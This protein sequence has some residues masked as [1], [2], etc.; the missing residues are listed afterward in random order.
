MKASE[1]KIIRFLEGHDKSFIIPVYQRNYDWNKDNCKQLFD[2]LIDVIKNKRTSHFF[3]SIVYLDNEETDEN[4]RELVI[5]DGQQRITTLTLLMIA[6]LHIHEEGKND[7]KLDTALIKDEY[8]V[9]KYTNK[10]KVKL[11]PVK[12]DAAALK[13]IFDKNWRD[14]SASNLVA[15]YLYFKE[16][17]QK[18]S[19]LP[20][21]IFAAIKRLDIVDIR[22]KNSEDDPQLIFESLNS[23]GLDLSEAD[24]VRN[25]ILMRLSNDKQNEY[26]EKFWNN[27]E[28]NTK[29]NVSGF[30]RD[31]LTYKERNI[32]KEDRVYFTF[33]KYA[34]DSK[35]T[36]ENI[37]EELLIFSEYYS[38]IISSE[39]E[40]KGIKEMLTYL[41]KLNMTVTYPFLLEVF[42]DYYS[43]KIISDNDLFEI[44]SI[45][46]AFIIR[47][48]ICEVPTNALNKLFM[49]LGRE[50]KDL[51]DYKE[52]YVKIF[53]YIL[54]QKR[55][56]QRFPNDNE[57]KGRMIVKDLYNMNAKNSMHILERL[58]NFQNREKID[59]QKLLA[60]NILT[61][62]H[63]MPQ[64]LSKKW[65]DEIGIEHEFIHSTY[66]HTIGNLTLT[67]Y[68][69]EM[70]NKSFSEKKT[71][72]GGFEQS[73]L[74]LNEYVKQ[75]DAWNK[76][77]I[78]ERADILANRALK[79]WQF[80]A[81]DY[82]SSKDIENTYSL[83]EDINFTG[84][85][86][87]YFTFRGQKI[88]VNHW[89]I[90]LQQLCRVLYDMEPIK[91]RNLMYDDEFNKKPLLLSDDKSKLRS[92][93]QIT[94]DIFMEATFNTN[95][96]VYI[97]KQILSKLDIDMEEVNI[98][99]QEDKI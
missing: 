30:L 28:K 79:I 53:K 61:I 46:E 33:K 68:N 39:H 67:A 82:K 78:I 91:F 59:I 76:N 96:R 25:F 17:L 15:N 8:L 94:E 75:Q 60:E 2:D 36:I 92:V 12:N 95:Y 98:C 47:R 3:G 52:N 50:I 44:L 37:L 24:K 21:E 69:S 99:L 70:S 64:T 77:T 34:Q 1:K 85:K 22:L 18:T 40:N 11:K 63:I 58:E 38:R 51:S 19:A 13:A 20:S 93:L 83:S 88:E 81:T 57:L 74:Y 16:L 45:L 87:K 29:Y 49:V 26:Y 48:I 6:L 4:G 54:L 41:N 90:F 84:T 9:G 32:P 97:A 73:K 80:C 14:Y 31:Y 66:L 5:I 62:E 89:I 35:L 71:I 56:S 55:G 72:D 10:E 65:K 42:N 23:T 86:L 43:E 27:I 7:D